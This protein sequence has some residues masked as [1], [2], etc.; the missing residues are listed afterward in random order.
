MSVV[1]TRFSVETQAIV[2]RQAFGCGTLIGCISDMNV[3]GTQESQNHRGRL[4]E[5]LRR[6]PQF[7]QF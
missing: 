1:W 7:Q 5:G 6:I 4:L 2:P 3:Q